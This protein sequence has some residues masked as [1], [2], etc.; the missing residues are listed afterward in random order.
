MF[1]SGSMGKMFTAAAVLSLVERG[2][3]DLEASIRTYL[4]EASA[5]WEPIRLR[6]LLTHTSG[7]PDYTSDTFDYRK[8][9]PEAELAKVAFAQ[10]LEFPA[11]QRR[12]Y[13]NT[14]YVLLGVIVSKVTG[15][16]YWE[17]LRERLFMPA[18]M[19]TARIMSEADIVPNRSAGYLVDAKGQYTNQNWVAPVTNTTADGSLLLSVD[20]MIAWA[21]AIRDRRVIAP[22]SWARVQSP[23]TLNSGKPYPYG[24]GWFVETLNGTP[25]LQHGGLQSLEPLARSAEGDDS[26]Y[27]YRARFAEGIVRAQVK[28]GPGGRL[29]RLQL[30]RGE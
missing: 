7:I 2:T 18:G 24:M 16:P 30:R 22:A 1:E 19:P 20:D 27:T 21:R 29:T 25:Y 13:S 23:V 3:L 11:G 17:Y 14:G 4:P 26:V 12:N 6:H 15:R 10:T 28:L 8:D 5:A 9:Y